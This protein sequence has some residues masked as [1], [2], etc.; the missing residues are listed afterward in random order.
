MQLRAGELF[1][2]QKA[3]AVTH[4]RSGATGVLHSVPSSP[5]LIACAT[6]AAFGGLDHFAVLAAFMA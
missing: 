3:R 6:A 1:W 4:S 5:C 2:R